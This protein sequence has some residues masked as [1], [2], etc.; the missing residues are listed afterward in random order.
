MERE[1]GT[2]EGMEK[3]TRSPRAG[4]AASTAR[5]EREEASTAREVTMEGAGEE[6]LVA[7]G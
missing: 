3:A 7:H 1:W 2:V 5:A 4:A 6:S